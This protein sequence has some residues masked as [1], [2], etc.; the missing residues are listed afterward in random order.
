VYDGELT[1]HSAYARVLD[2]L[3]GRSKRS[4]VTI[5]SAWGVGIPLWAVVSIAALLKS[6]LGRTLVTSVVTD[7]AVLAEYRLLAVWAEWYLAIFVALA[8]GCLEGLG[9]SSEIAASS[10][11]FASSSSA[12]KRRTA[13]SPLTR[14]SWLIAFLEIVHVCDVLVRCVNYIIRI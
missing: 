1:L 14:A 5:V 13:E 6:T 11:E 7:K 4:V 2:G 9:R 3:C 10:T 8:A 12:P